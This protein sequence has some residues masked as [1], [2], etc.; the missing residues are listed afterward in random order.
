MMNHE[1]SLLSDTSIYQFL[2]QGRNLVPHNVSFP[3]N[4]PNQLQTFNA[5]TAHASSLRTVLR[6]ISKFSEIYG[7]DRRAF[8][9]AW[10]ASFL[11]KLS[12]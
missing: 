6:G 2:S 3:Q 10:S 4:W 9:N 5:E 12:T 1:R 7:G 11:S 8:F